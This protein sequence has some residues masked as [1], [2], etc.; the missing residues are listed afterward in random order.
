MLKVDWD[1]PGRGV[2]NEQVQ[3]Y[4]AACS[5]VEGNE[6]Y[7]LKHTVSVDVF[8]GF[9]PIGGNISTSAYN[10]CVEAVFETYSSKMCITT[11]SQLIVDDNNHQHST[12]PSTTSIQMV[13]GIAGALTSVIVI[14]L[15][16]L[17][18]AVTALICM[19]RKIQ[20][21][22]EHPK[23]YVGGIKFKSSD[24]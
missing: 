1:V 11:P 10:C 8:E 6:V 18:V 14:L 9:L 2:T 7:T 3:S 19:W 24:L 22:E 15:I 12:C 17:L 20:S 21:K 5:F 13:A 16:L 4:V 23:M